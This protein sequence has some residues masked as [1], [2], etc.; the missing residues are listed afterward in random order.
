MYHGGYKVGRQSR[1]K[2]ASYVGIV[3]SVHIGRIAKHGPQEL[4]TAFVQAMMGMIRLSKVNG[5]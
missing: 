1:Y 2:F 5:G 3:P 4:K